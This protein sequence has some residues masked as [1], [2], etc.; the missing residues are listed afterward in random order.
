[1]K[2]Q[3]LRIFL[4]AL[5]LGLYFSLPGVRSLPGAEAALTV[6]D[7]TTP[8]AEDGEEAGSDDSGGEESD[9]DV[10]DEE[11]SEEESD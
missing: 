11:S 5:G 1:M 7:P 6:L 3:V 8:R 4:A 2:L 9:G 10:E